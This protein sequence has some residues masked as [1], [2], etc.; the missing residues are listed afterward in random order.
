MSAALLCTSS[1]RHRRGGCQSPELLS[2]HIQLPGEGL[3]CSV[4]CGFTPDL[5]RWFILELIQISANGSGPSFCHHLLV[6]PAAPR[7]F[8]CHLLLH[9][10]SGEKGLA[11][12]ERLLWIVLCQ[13]RQNQGGFGASSSSPELSRELFPRG[14]GSS[15]HQETDRA[16]KSP[17]QGSFGAS[18][19][20]K[21]TSRH[22]FRSYFNRIH[23]V[24]HSI[25]APQPC[26]L[27]F[28]CDYLLATQWN[29]NWVS[30][31]F[32]S[33]S[34]NSCM[35]FPAYLSSDQGLGWVLSWWPFGI[36]FS[37]LVG[38]KKIIWCPKILCQW[39]CLLDLIKSRMYIH[40]L[41]PFSAYKK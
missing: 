4:C 5:W 21:N 28:V 18:T 33:Y 34:E 16:Q 9:V 31:V 11:V 19:A 13:S 17:T 2:Q 15:F 20:G 35:K 22:I 38:S 24:V 6:V 7:V 36:L 30:C 29:G 26:P 10:C 39:K 40:F 23:Q 3:A 1:K 14:M 32:I 25:T 41:Y 37:A 27:R 8:R 12:E